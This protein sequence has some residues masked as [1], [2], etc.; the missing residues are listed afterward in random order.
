MHSVSTVTFTYI[1][2]VMIV[3]ISEQHF[4]KIGETFLSSAA[5]DL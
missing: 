2:I 3:L 5:F 4:S 1:K